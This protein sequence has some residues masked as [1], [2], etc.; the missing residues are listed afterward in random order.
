MDDPAA[1]GEAR[2]QERG[3]SQYAFDNVDDV[4]RACLGETEDDGDD[5]PA[6]GVFADGGGDDDLSEV[7]SGKAHFA[8]DRRH[9]LDRRNG[10]R[11]AEEQGGEQTLIRMRKEPFWQELTEH[12]PTNERNCDAGD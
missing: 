7:A 1:D 6:N 11:G 5:H 4:D 8:H 3:R 10:Q 2:K 12:K 9:N